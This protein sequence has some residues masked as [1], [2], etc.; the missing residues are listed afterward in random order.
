[1]K[2]RIFK[3]LARRHFFDWLSDEAYIK[4]MY[5]CIMDRKVN[6]KNPQTFNEKLQWLKLYNRNP[7]YTMMVDKYEVKKYIAETIGEEYL[8]PTLGIYSSFNEI[9]FNKLPNQFVIKCTHDSGGVVICKDKTKL[10][11]NSARE[12]INKNLKNNFFYVGREWPY[13]DVKPRIIIEEYIDDHKNED[14]NDYKFMC[15]NGKVKCSFVCSERRS[16]EGLKVTFFDLDWN[17]MPFERHYPYSKKN[18]AKP[19]NYT[20]MIELSEKLSKNLP[21]VRID[22]YEVNGKIYFGEI[23]FFPG[24]GTEEF[25][26]EEYDYLLGSWIEL[27]ERNKNEK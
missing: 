9:D 26:P 13:K 23:T 15:F 5:Y 19:E 11:I 3:G 7:I 14:L 22:F 4:L 10:D 16:K 6:L 25:T 20:K 1:M 18:I 27:P 17:K 12:K 2:S 8:I 24:N 21:F